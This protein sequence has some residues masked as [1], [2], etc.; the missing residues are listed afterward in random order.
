MTGKYWIKL[1]HEILEDPK[2][3]RLDDRLYRRV[4][5]LF[6]LAGRE[7]NEGILPALDDMA[8]MLRLNAEELETDLIEIQKIG[9]I[10]NI[11]GRWIV[12][13]FAN[14]QAPM[15]KA[16]FM[17]RKRV[18]ERSD[19]Y[20]AEHYPPVTEGVTDSN[21]DKKRIDKKRVEVEEV[22]PLKILVNSSGLPDFPGSQRQYI[23]IVHR[24]AEDHG[25]EKTT[26]AMKQ[27]F[28]QWT[29]T[30]GKSGAFYRASNISWIDWA[31]AILISDDLPEKDISQMSDK[32]FL[33][34]LEKENANA[35]NNNP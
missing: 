28:G 4:I 10:G 6:V 18:T 34:W 1:Y 26:E 23:E 20:Q 24:M 5:E 14:R 8:I 25:I 30:R 33:S 2:M 3:I 29:K 15:S 27:A 35:E 17:R 19:E 7:D 32:E 21:T 22:D 31:M 13:K 12:A 16:E 9:I 11:D